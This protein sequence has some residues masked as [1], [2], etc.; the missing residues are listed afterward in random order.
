M[1]DRFGRN[2]RHLRVTRGVS[3]TDFAREVGY[4]K[5]HMSAIETGKQW[6]SARML[7]AIAYALDTSIDALFEGV[8]EGV[9]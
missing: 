7:P 6:P 4:G 3:L 1:L 5:A 2:L 9:R 8:R